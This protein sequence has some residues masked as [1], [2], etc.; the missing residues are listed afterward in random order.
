MMNKRT[1]GENTLRI[2]LNK[3]VLK[4]KKT[5]KKKIDSPQIPC[6]QI[7]FFSQHY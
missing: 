6:F 4:D 3:Y 2:S 1:V 5:P 7:H